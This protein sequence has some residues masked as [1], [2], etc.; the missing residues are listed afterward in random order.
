MICLVGL[1]CTEPESLEAT[2]QA[3]GPDLSWRNVAYLIFTPQPGVAVQKVGPAGWNAGAS[4]GE[5][6]AGDGWIEF[7]ATENTT[8]RMIGL[9]KGDDSV[10][11]EDIDFAIHLKANGTLG[12]FEDGLLRGSNF[13][14]Y[15]AGDLLRVEVAGGIVRYSKNGSVFYTS[16]VRPR[17]PLVV[18]MSF[19]TPGGAI[20]TL[21]FVHGG[22]NWQNAVGVAVSGSSITKTGPPGWNAGAST[23]ERIPGFGFVE[24][25]TGENT[26]VKVAGLSRGDANQDWTDIDYGIHLRA[27]GTIGIREL[28]AQVGTTF[29]TYVAGDVFRISVASGVVTYA[30]NGVDFYTSTVA[31]SFEMQLDTSLYTP[32]AT[33]QDVMFFEAVFA[34]GCP[35]TLD[36]GVMICPGSFYIENIF[37]LMELNQCQRVTGHVVIEGFGL[38]V[39]DVP[40]LQ[41]VDGSLILNSLTLRRVIL[42]DLRVIG[43][44]LS[45][46]FTLDELALPRLHTLGAYQGEGGVSTVAQQPLPCLVDVTETL[47]PFTSMD[48]P[49]L[50]TVGSGVAGGPL[51]APDLTDV[52]GG[53]FYDAGAH[54]PS[55]VHTGML[56]L[57]SIDEIDLPSLEDVD[58]QLVL[59]CPLSGMTPTNPTETALELPA[60]KTV[61]SLQLCP[62][63]ALTSVSLPSLE[64][65]LGPPS[66]GGLEIQASNHIAS[67]DFPSLTKVFGKADLQIASDLPSLLAVTGSLTVTGV[68][69]TAGALETVGNRVQLVRTPLA[70]LPSLR[71]IDFTLQIRGP[72]TAFVDL[73]SLESVGGP[74]TVRSTGLTELLVPALTSISGY[75]SIIDN[76]VLADIDFSALAALGGDLTIGN[77][78]QLPNCQATGLVDQLIAAGWTGDA[79]VFGNGTGTCP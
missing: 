20:G 72:T 17:F 39:V 45:G 25:T 43:G 40:G 24:F 41:V 54:Y 77:N 70:S 68:D 12:V 74:M 44:Q 61:G 27:N 28:G 33:I 63:P 30:K 31:P 2:E 55:L 48:A 76:D 37:D 14:S 56:W 11:Y 46:N 51:R 32:G 21:D 47:V 15:V 73:S 4:S 34:D 1:G 6:L 8:A 71:T 29:G 23:F 42:E 13:G 79:N 18:D 7:S 69:I 60:L 67:I 78:P 58:D 10:A 53:V 57:R 38:E 22:G 59:G 64:R 3:V 62:W 9:S 5:A 52:G 35:A 50:E 26:T 16:T 66:L 19:S 36:P 75:L 49:R 65:V